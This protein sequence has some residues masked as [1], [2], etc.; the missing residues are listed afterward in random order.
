MR[1]NWICVPSE[2][3]TKYNQ[4]M[5]IHHRHFYTVFS[6]NRHFY[7][8]L[9]SLLF[10]QFEHKFYS[11]QKTNSSKMISNRNEKMLWAQH[12]HCLNVFGIILLVN[13]LLSIVY[14]EYCIPAFCFRAPLET[15]KRRTR[16]DT[17]NVSWHQCS[18]VLEKFIENA[19]METLWCEVNFVAIS[20]YEYQRIAR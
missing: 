18:N 14:C 9:T 5:R 12:E 17:A 19:C 10:R 3:W 1:L 16:N 8:V 7:A 13:L 20:R 6:W 4:S 11:W 2:S 15:V